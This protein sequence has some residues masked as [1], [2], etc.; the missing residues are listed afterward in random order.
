[1]NIPKIT[2]FFRNPK[3]GISIGRVFEQISYCISKRYETENINMQAGGASIKQVLSNLRY[4]YQHRNKDGINHITGAVHYLSFVLPKKN[5]ITTVHDLGM[6]YNKD[7]KLNFLKRK[8]LYLLLV[9][10]LRRNKIIVCVSDYTKRVLLKHLNIPANRVEVIPDPI[11]EGFV[12]SPKKF[13]SSLPIILHIGTK[14]NKN[15]LRTIAAL[16]GLKVRLRIIGKLSQ[17]QVSALEESGLIY[18]NAYGLTDDEIVEEYK[19]CDIVNVTSTYEGFGMPII[20]A[21]AVG[22]ICVT[23]NIEPMITVASDAACLVDPYDIESIRE[24]YLRVL[25]SE[26]Y[27]QQLIELGR[28]NSRKYS[29]NSVVDCYLNIYSKI[30]D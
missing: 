26:E 30:I 7:I 3:D 24:G 15:L 12:F 11:F 6:L 8:L 10:P 27:R 25:G 13:N 19:N 2:Y 22:R 16:S 17:E 20:E 18:S 21:Q 23:S 28:I 4:T 1:M 29:L 14:E 9:W 5:T